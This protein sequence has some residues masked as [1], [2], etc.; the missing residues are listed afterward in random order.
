MYIYIFRRFQ[1]NMQNFLCRILSHINVSFI[2]MYLCLVTLTE[3]QQQKMVAMMMARDASQ[4]DWVVMLLLLLFL[5]KYLLI[6]LLFLFSP[7]SQRRLRNKRTWTRL[8]AMRKHTQVTLHIRSYSLFL[9]LFVFYSSSLFWPS[10][11]ISSY[12]NGSS[13]FKL[14]LHQHS[15]PWRNQLPRRFID[16]KRFL[17]L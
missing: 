12:Q 8:Q 1:L 14:V 11:F 17:T 7:S 5:L 13:K 6:S 10:L 4:G 15:L 3:N 2:P 9:I 16:L